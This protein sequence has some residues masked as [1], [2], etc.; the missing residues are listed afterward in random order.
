MFDSG[1]H[2]EA[3]AVVWTRSIL[4]QQRRQPSVQSDAS[5][6]FNGGSCCGCRHCAVPRLEVIAT[7]F[8]S[9]GGHSEPSEGRKDVQPARPVDKDKS[10]DMPI[11]V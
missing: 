11:D 10:V 4:L 2:N 5:N 9:G 3:I 8:G 7:V 6:R 1:L